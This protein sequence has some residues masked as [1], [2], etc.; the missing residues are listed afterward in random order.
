MKKISIL[1]TFSLGLLVFV[2]PAKA[3][4]EEHEFSLA[5]LES[6][7]LM[8]QADTRVA[9]ST[10]TVKGAPAHPYAASRLPALD[11]GI[12]DMDTGIDLVIPFTGSKNASVQSAAQMLVE[13]FESQ[14]NN[15]ATQIGMTELVAKNPEAYASI[16]ESDENNLANLHAQLIKNMTSAATLTLKALYPDANPLKKLTIS[17]AQKEE[18]LATVEKKFPGAKAEATKVEQNATVSW[19]YI[20]SYFSSH[21]APY[22]PMPDL[23][24]KKEE[25][26]F[27]K[28]PA[29][30]KK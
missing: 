15:F 27:K 16:R 13:S 10:K 18:L 28:Q 11:F 2:A 24:K 6:L 22:E 21:L 19:D 9:V 20:S 1:L 7:S 23:E 26:F 17:K 8:K 14:R 29:T 3:A 12:K 4:T 25:D 5:F 30:E